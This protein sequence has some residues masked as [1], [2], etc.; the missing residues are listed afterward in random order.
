VRFEVCSHESLRL[1]STHLTDRDTLGIRATPY[2]GDPTAGRTTFAVSYSGACADPTW[3]RVEMGAVSI[4]RLTVVHKSC[5]C[6][7]VKDSAA[8][9]EMTELSKG[10][11]V[12][13]IFSSMF[14]SLEL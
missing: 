7:H 14:E 1:R 12:S 13:K 2:F 5:S 8:H 4:F 9:N 6:S 10:F 11:C 3:R